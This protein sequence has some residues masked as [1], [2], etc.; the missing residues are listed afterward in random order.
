LYGDLYFSDPRFIR[1]EP[2]SAAPFVETDHEFFELSGP[3]PTA[4]KE[5]RRHPRFYY[6]ACAEAIIHPLGKREGGP[7]A[8]QCFLLTRDLSRGGVGLVHVQ[9]LFPGQRIDVILNGE[10]PR[11]VEVVWCR[12]WTHN[13]YVAGCRFTAATG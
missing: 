12:R 8:T 11:Q 5:N 7:E 13:R 3:M 9:Q 1:L 6:R 2:M 4:W 10:A